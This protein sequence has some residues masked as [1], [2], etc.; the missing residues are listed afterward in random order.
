MKEAMW[1][2]GV[3]VVGLFGLILI[4]LFG[5][6]TTTNQQNYELMKNATEAAMYDAIDQDAYANGFCLC[7]NK[8]VGKGTLAVFT[9][10]SQYKVRNLDEDGFCS[11]DDYDTCALIRHEYMIK[12]NV[13][14]ETFVRRLADV[15]KQNVEYKLDVLDVIEYPP[16]V[17]V[18]VSSND[19]YDHFTTADE[20]EYSIV[21]VYD[22][23][24]ESNK[25]E[26]EIILPSKLTV[27]LVEKG[28]GALIPGG[29]IT[30]TGTNGF[31]KSWN[32]S[33]KNPNV[34]KV[35][36]GHFE[37]VETNVPEGYIGGAKGEVDVED[38]GGEYVII[39]EDEKKPP[40]PPM[41][42]SCSKYYYNVHWLKYAAPSD[43][44]G[45]LGL[46]CTAKQRSYYHTKSG[47]TSYDSALSACKSYATNYVNGKKVKTNNT[48]E[49][50]CKAYN[51]W[52]WSY[53]RDDGSIQYS[54]SLFQTS[55]DARKNCLLAH[56]P[57]RCGQVCMW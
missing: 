53:V 9:D 21:N 16:K 2:V 38:G 22:S 41:S 55:S 37:A 39:L 26:I 34:F 18:Q 35:W 48:N 15:L 23:I 27:K 57:E 24:L 13:F 33:D 11:Y 29:K 25:D 36:G 31:A 44:T 40:S 19:N 10:K 1:G 54:I 20:G 6:I 50:G 56:E 32:T 3:V 5:N 51:S 7:T 43:C 17:S 46:V 14:R 52:R 30:L 12:E 47:Y 8:K 45:F 42:S 28:S 4:D 49:N